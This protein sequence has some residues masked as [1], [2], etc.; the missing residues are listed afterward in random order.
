MNEFDLVSYITRQREWSGRTFGAGKRTGGIIEHITKEIAEI[1]TDPSD[2][3]EWVDVVILA[4]DGAWRAGWS[5]REIVDGLAAKQR[6][7]F[8]RTWPTPESEDRAVEHV[9]AGLAGRWS[10]AELTGCRACRCYSVGVV[11]ALD[12]RFAHK[13][14]HAGRHKARV[15][16]YAVEG[17]AQEVGVPEWCP[18]IMAG[19]VEL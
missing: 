10:V 14:N 13:C 7:N 5:P 16:R 12:Q 6:I 11:T 19:G 4:L 17:P 9:R 18:L 8:A 1:K 3:M 15:I 2:P